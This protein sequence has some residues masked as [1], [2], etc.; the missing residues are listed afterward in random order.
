MKILCLGA[1]PDDIELMAGGTILKLVSEGHQVFGVVFTDGSW[2]LPDGR[3]ARDPELAKQ[4]NI[5]AANYL[6][7]D[8][9]WLNETALN[10]TYCDRLVVEVLNIIEAKEIDTLILPYFDDLHKDHRIVNELGIAASRRIPRVLHGQINYFMGSFFTPNFFVDIS[11]TYSKKIEALSMFTSV[12]AKNAQNWEEFLHATHTY[13]G[14][15]IG[16]EKAEGFI[17]KKYLL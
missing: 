1:H 17:T 9:L 3:I 7:Y 6:N 5:N 10:L 14:K 8:L 13:Y 11:L 2:S 4:E 12:W 16:T 15:I